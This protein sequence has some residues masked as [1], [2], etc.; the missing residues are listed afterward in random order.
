MRAR[1]KFFKVCRP[2]ASPVSKEACILVHGIRG[3]ILA[4]AR[5][6]RRDSSLCP[7]KDKGF[8]YYIKRK[9]G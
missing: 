3:A 6:Y 1:Q 2:G 8:F 4:Q 9:D 7:I 5:W